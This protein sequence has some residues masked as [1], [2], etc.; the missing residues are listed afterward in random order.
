MALKHSTL[1]IYDYVTERRSV[2]I[3]SYQLRKYL[4]NF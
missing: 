4:E 1:F 3:W 2:I